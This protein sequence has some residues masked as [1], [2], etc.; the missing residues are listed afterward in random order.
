MGVLLG[1][2]GLGIGKPKFLE[3]GGSKLSITEHFVLM[4]IP[5]WRKC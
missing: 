5:W 1:G 2:I 3:V 4:P